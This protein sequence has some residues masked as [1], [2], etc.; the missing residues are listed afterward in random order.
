MEYS[1]AHDTIQQ[2]AEPRKESKLI[3]I[4][5]GIL[6]ACLF[7][8]VFLVPVWFLPFTIDVLE[9]NKQTVLV[10]LTMIALMA[11]LGK[12]VLQKSI[13]LSRSWLHVVVGVYVL[14]Y[15]GTSLFSQDRYLSLAGNF[16]QMQWAFVTIAAFGVMYFVLVNTVKNTTRLYDLLLTFLGSSALVAI[17]GLLQV[18]GVHLLGGVFP[19][20]ATRT[21]NSIGTVNALAMFLVVPIVLAVSLL[22]LGC[23]DEKCVLGRKGK[24]Q[25]F[26]ASLVWAMLVLGVAL[27]TVVDFWAAWTAI[28]FGTL[29]VLGVSTARRRS[30]GKPLSLIAPAILCALSIALL[31]WET[32]LKVNLPGEVSPSLSHSWQ[33]A[34]QVLQEHPIGGSGPGTWIYDYSKYRSPAVNISQFWS[35]RFERGVSSFLTLIATVGIMGISLWLILLI[36]AVTKSLSH[37]SRESNDDV[38]QAHLTVF[39]AWATSAF[40]SF[41]ANFNLA[42][43]FTFW[44]LLALLAALVATGSYTWDAVRKPMTV[45]VL[46]IVFLVLCIGAISVTWLAGQRLV[47]D[48]NYSSAVLSF[49][50]GK[51]IQESV[52]RL[53]AAVALNRLNDAYYRNLSQAYLIRASQVVQGKDSDKGRLVNQLVSASIDTA[54][55]A[56]EISSAN[57]DNW[58]NLAMVYQAIASFT[59]G[60]DEFAIKNYQE[61]LAREPNNP[62]FYNEIGKLYI[63]RA[64]AYRT[65]LSSKDE[66][67]RLDA[68][69]NARA[70]LDKAAEQLNQAIQAKPDFANAHYNLGILYERQGR[71]QEAIAKMEDVL[72]TNNRDVGVGFQLGILYYRNGEKDK[73]QYILEQII[74]ID[75]SYG[76]ARWYLSTLYEESGRYDDAIAQVKQLLQANPDNA[77]IA[78]RLDQLVKARDAKQVPKV[79]PIPEP[80]P[81]EIKGPKSLNEVKK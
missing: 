76:N 5:D 55:R 23:R 69:S 3:R 59:R 29:C 65:L 15:L 26:A 42:H 34:K 12:A 52:D 28:L 13:R 1:I 18:F 38:W 71:L 46:S 36:S 57:V 19:Q 4:L 33:I 70:E 73:A 27:V 10:M 22:V 32:P 24:C 31:V 43:G 2:G 61:A 75:P 17:F 74:T 67:T 40:I 8:V 39:S 64:D 81:E 41:I 11:W 63:L 25:A 53:N 51:Q 37:L 78:Q 6:C 80:I 72:R 44:F 45:T 20:S 16:G 48:A 60:A 47:A 58:A 77:T 9:M 68:E 49:R 66:K 56:T 7:A 30:I 21:F 62:V 14:G 79:Q 35:V 54:K 50:S